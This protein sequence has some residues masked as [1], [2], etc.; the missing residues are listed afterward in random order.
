MLERAKHLANSFANIN[1]ERHA[2][3][4]EEYHSAV[5]GVNNHLTRY[6]ILDGES[7]VEWGR[8]TV[9]MGAVA[10][11]GSIGFFALAQAFESGD[12]VKAITALT[13]LGVAAR[14]AKM[15]IR[16][17]DNSNAIEEVMFED[18]KFVFASSKK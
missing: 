3:K 9:G 18:P 12:P 16:A 7:V 14:A 4:V 2:Q 17:N 5:E 10:T 15:P 1:S 6:Q 11:L 8:F 13:T